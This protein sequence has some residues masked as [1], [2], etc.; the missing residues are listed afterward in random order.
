MDEIKKLREQGKHIHASADTYYYKER[1]ELITQYYERLAKF[2]NLMI[3]KGLSQD[4]DNIQRKILV[5]HRYNL[6]YGSLYLHFYAFM[7]AVEL[8][9][10]DEQAKKWLPLIND[11]KITGAYAQT[12]V[13][14][15]SDVQNLQ[16]TAA[17]DQHSQELVFHTPNIGATKF[18]PGGLGK[19]TTHCVLYARLIS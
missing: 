18:W 3:E 7:P 15:G 10:S 8:L 17:Y 13:G 1:E 6:D 11:L 14:H 4:Q 16:T 19:S 9:A 5:L 2:Q 12:E